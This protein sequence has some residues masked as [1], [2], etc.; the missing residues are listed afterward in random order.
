MNFRAAND[1]FRKFETI[2]PSPA[3]TLFKNMYLKIT[4]FYNK[5]KFVK[6]ERFVELRYRFRFAR[7]KPYFAHIGARTI[8]EDFNVWDGKSGN[9]SVG[10]NC[11]FGLHN[12]VM[13]P[14]EIGDNVQTGPN[15]SI[16]GMRHPVLKTEES[17]RDKTI[18]GNNVWISTGSIIMF[19]VKIG[20]N[21][22]IGAGSVVTKDV[23]E[24]SFVAGNP[25]RDL[26]RLATVKWQKADLHSNDEQA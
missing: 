3:R 8:V 21:A 16:L 18:I 4:R 2:V 23:A 13:G 1:S 11:W 10:K 22:I 14:I 9:I 6:K 26:T 20:D 17:K 19:G 24:D 15:V 25:A 7:R 12:I 5:K